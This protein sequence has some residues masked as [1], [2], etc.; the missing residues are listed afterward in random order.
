MLEY[1]NLHTGT[2][3][4]SGWI[5][6]NDHYEISITNENVKV[7]SVVDVIF[8][9]DTKAELDCISNAQISGYKQEVGKVTI[10][11]WGKQPTI[12]LD[13]NLVVRGGL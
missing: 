4:A 8:N 11:A 10:Y 6:N 12:N 3:P 7:D 9:S 2:L 5:L 13:Y 1:S